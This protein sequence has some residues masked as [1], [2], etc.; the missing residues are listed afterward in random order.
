M[1]EVAYCCEFLSLQY[2]ALLKVDDIEGWKPDKYG[3]IAIYIL[4]P[5][6]NSDC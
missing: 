1:N 4:K 2:A 5:K 6:C 3:A